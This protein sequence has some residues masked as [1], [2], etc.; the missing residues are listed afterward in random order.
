M[1]IVYMKFVRVFGTLKKVLKRRRFGPIEDTS[2]SRWCNGS[3]SSPGSS[4]RRG[5]IGW[6]V[7]KPPASGP[8]GGGGLFLTA[9]AHSSR[10]KKESIPFNSP[11]VK[12][13]VKDCQRKNLRSTNSLLMHGTES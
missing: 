3:S 7:N 2:N 10:T 11:H 8:G 12:V 1:R 5:H 9:S 4:L 6:S 13:H